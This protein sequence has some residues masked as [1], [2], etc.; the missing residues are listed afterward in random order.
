[1]RNFSS[2]IYDI[3]TGIE[4]KL[5]I[6]N[7]KSVSRY[8]PLNMCMPTDS[9]V[10][11]ENGERFARKMYKAYLL[12]DQA[13]YATF[14]LTAFSKECLNRLAKI[15][16]YL[17]T[18]RSTPTD[19]VPLHTY[20][21][22]CSNIPLFRYDTYADQYVYDIRCYR[23]G[24]CIDLA[25]QEN[26]MYLSKWQC[27]FNDVSIKLNASLTLIET[28]L[29]IA[30]RPSSLPP[31]TI[32]SL[33]I[34]SPASTSDIH[35]SHKTMMAYQLANKSNLLLFEC[36]NIISE[37]FNRVTKINAVIANL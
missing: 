21:S 15:Y 10:A 25:N 24:D 9:D 26:D 36:Q 19:H 30:Y 13:K 11:G 29:R 1:M 2:A 14:L 16:V 18:V 20:V 27:I 31:F 37:I 22:T 23:S 7:V 5:N 35:F 28:K 32:S 3:M 12:S 33:C 34:N 4:T 17:P 6:T 8:I